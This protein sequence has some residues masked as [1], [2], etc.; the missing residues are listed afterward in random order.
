MLVV[1]T[2]TVIFFGFVVLNVAVFFSSERSQF[3]TGM[4]SA[5]LR[6]KR[7]KEGQRPALSREDAARVSPPSGI[8]PASRG[9]ARRL[10]LIGAANASPAAVSGNVENEGH[11]SF[12]L[13]TRPRNN[14][15]DFLE[16]GS[17]GSSNAATHYICSTYI[18][19]AMGDHG[20]NSGCSDQDPLEYPSSMRGTDVCLFQAFTDNPIAR[21]S[22]SSSSASSSREPTSH[23]MPPLPTANR[24]MSPP[25]RGPTS[26]ASSE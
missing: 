9:S 17:D 22:T 4:R 23:A 13:S 21:V 5:G 8:Q 7:N 2:A 14:E 15:D 26:P 3:K 20:G 10:R 6:K 25:L 12:R 11:A 16:V 19:S 18:G 24:A 1:L